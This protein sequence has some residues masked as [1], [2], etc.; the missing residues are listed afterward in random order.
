M[1]NRIRHIAMV[2][3]AATL[4]LLSSCETE[5]PDKKGPSHVM[6]MYMLANNNLIPFLTDNVAQVVEG[7][8][9]RFPDNATIL[10]YWDGYDLN[11]GADATKLCEIVPPSKKGERATIEVIKTYKARNSA[12][13][14]V[15]KEVIEYVKDNYPSEIYGMVLSSHGTGWVPPEL[16]TLTYPRTPGIA[17]EHDL[18]RPE[19]ALTRAFGQD[20]KS[21]LWMSVEEVREGLSAF[22]GQLDYIIFDAC[23]MASIEALYDFRFSADYIVASP[24]EIMGAGMPF[25]KIVPTLFNEADKS[26]EKRLTA[27]ASIFVEYYRVGSDWNIPSAAAVVVETSKL[28]A[29]AESVKNIFDKPTNEVDETIIQP[30]ESL[31]NHI[32]FDLDDYI[33]N[34]QTD[35]QSY[36]AFQVAL[37]AAVL[38]EGHTA[39]VYSI[40]GGEFSVP[41]LPTNKVCGITS[42]IPRDRYP[43][44]KGYYYDTAWAKATQPQQ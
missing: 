26:I 3:L 33:Y 16:N 34:L 40:Y 37:N 28:D 27:T 2:L 5:G 1:K 15:M 10:V 30:Y 31:G 7:V 29:L 13:P 6:L 43:V 4:V 39:R 32:F 35:L 14:E 36:A 22:D 20:G 17:I 24:S 41:K 11:T 12:T 19:D 44:T 21:S 9:Y 25:H 42:Y 8:N 18:S 38:F 23:F